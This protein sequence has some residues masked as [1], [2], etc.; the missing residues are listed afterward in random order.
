MPTLSGTT[1]DETSSPVARLVRAY[2]RD[3]GAF[4][5]EAQS[6]PT[7]GGWSI[8]TGDFD[9]HCFAVC[10]SAGYED[11]HWGSVAVLLRMDGADNGTLFADEKGRTV[12]PFGNA[13]TRMNE[14]MTGMTSAYFD[15]AGDYLS[16]AYHSSMAVGANDFTVE[17]WLAVATNGTA[18]TLFDTRAGGTRPG[19]SLQV[20]ADNK[21]RF[22]ASDSDNTAYEVDITGTSTL[23]SGSGWKHV[24]VVRHGDDWIIF[25]DGVEEVR[26]TASFTVG[27]P[28]A[29]LIIGA[30]HTGTTSFLTGNIDEF[31]FTNGVARYTEDF[32]PLEDMLP[33]GLTGWAENA[34]IYDLLTP[35]Y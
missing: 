24:A 13:R 2:R 21:L 9:G 32:T 14:V 5:G 7:T 35:T 17:F 26:A 23:S 30:Y 34:L 29:P 31:R 27:N 10:H 12:T 20:G 28:A 1:F 16:V 18:R 4:L 15:G 25:L 3:T 8:D 22:V 11:P 33:A 19:M 6:N